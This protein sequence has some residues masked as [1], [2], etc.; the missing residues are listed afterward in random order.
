M[1]RPENNFPPLPPKICTAFRYLYYTRMVTWAP[2][3]SIPVRELTPLEKSVQTV[4]LR[5]LQQYMLGEMDFAEK[6]EADDK[7]K[8]ADAPAEKNP[9]GAA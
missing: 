4:A 9:G 2:D 6:L 1:D 8:P 3:V 7:E 5:A